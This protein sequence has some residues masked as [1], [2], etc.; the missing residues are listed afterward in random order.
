MELVRDLGC[1]PLAI[2][3][4]S[5]HAGV[6]GTARPG[7]FLAALKRVAPPQ[8]PQLEVG[9]KV[10]LH[11]LN[12]TEHNGK[13]GELLEFDA[14]AHRWAVELSEGGSIRVR[15][16]NLALLSRDDC[17]L[18]LHAVVMLSVGKIQESGDGEAADSALRKMELLDTTAI[19]LD[20]LSSTERKAV[21]V[22][23]QHA[24]VTMDDK[25]LGAIHSLTQLAVRCQVTWGSMKGNEPGIGRPRSPCEMRE[26]LRQVERALG[27]VRKPKCQRMEG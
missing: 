25:D 21:Q 8:S 2:G 22:L 6:H 23:K 9:A 3:L 26:S 20:L 13:H 16:P 10:E 17:P 14:E 18:S 4:A 24:L 19:P 11:S 15:A 5:A 7:E 12:A 1:L 27:E